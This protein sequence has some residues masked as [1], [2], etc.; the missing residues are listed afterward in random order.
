MRP[1]TRELLE[2]SREF[3]RG[4]DN[5]I[6]HTRHPFNFRQDGTPSIQISLTRDGLRGEIDVDYRS[7]SFPAGLFN[8]YLTGL[9]S[10]V[11][12]GN[13]YQKHRRKWEGLQDW[14]R[15]W[16]GLPLASS[17]GVSAEAESDLIPRLPRGG[18]GEVHDAV[19]DF[20]TAW[21]IE[22]R[23]EEAM[24]YVFE[25]ALDCLQPD[26]EI[27]VDYGMAPFQMLRD[28]Q[29]SNELIGPVPNLEDVA[30]GVVLT[31]PGLRQV[32]H[33]HGR[34]FSLYSVS[35]AVAWEF[36]C[37]NRRRPARERKRGS[38][39]YGEYYGSVFRL[40]TSDS[41]G[42]TMTLLWRKREKHWQIVPFGVEPRGEVASRDIP[43]LR[44]LDSSQVRTVSA[45]PGLLEAVEGFH[46]SWFQEKD[47]DEA[48]GYLV[49]EA[50][51][52]IN[53]FLEEVELRSGSEEEAAR[54]VRGGMVEMVSELGE[55]RRLE[56]VLVAAKGGTPE[57][58]VVPHAREEAFILL[59]LPDYVGEELGCRRRLDDAGH[60]PEA[61]RS[62]AYGNYYGTGFQLKVGD[63]ATFFLIWKKRGDEWKV[64]AYDLLVP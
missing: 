8:G 28:M 31:D 14:W 21:L 61:Q 49:P 46:L 54:S 50:S 36:D 26:P 32:Q 57:L 64:V 47:Y 4:A 48:F 34:Q 12:A 19:S 58:Y 37:A 18:R 63:P 62:L 9:N 25:T 51:L 59:S 10:D 24:A 40:A 3:K 13:N 38:S 60:V 56:D 27:E 1:E 41:V 2:R 45:A 35:D 29:L 42:E 52:C 20:L 16:F 15:G 17:P 44:L 30:K 53:L 43:D 23:P 33:P 22:R 6:F 55:Y 7:S 5:T 39:T 11:R